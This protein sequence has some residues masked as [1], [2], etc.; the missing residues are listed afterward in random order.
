MRRYISIMA[1]VLM[2]LFATSCEL[3]SGTTPNPDKANLLLWDRVCEVFDGHYQHILT[4]AQLNDTLRDARHAKKLYEYCVMAEELEGVYTLEYGSNRTY[5]IHTAGKKLEE[6]GEWSIEV[7]YGYYME[8]YKLGS[9]KGVVGEPTKFNIDFDDEYGYR[10]PYRNAIKADIEYSYND[11]DES[12]GVTF[13][14]AE[15]FSVEREATTRPDYIIEFKAVEPMEFCDGVLHSGLIDIVY[16]DNIL[17]TERSLT[18][19]I[20]NKFV[21]FYNIKRN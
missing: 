14:T 3:E 19:A 9:V 18:A 11:S 2:A 20:T 10:S 7:K 5:R 16:R 17:H 21:S 15:G 1:V 8:P 13:T 4:V 12:L 6:G